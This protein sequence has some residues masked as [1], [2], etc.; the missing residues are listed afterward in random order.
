MKEAFLSLLGVVVGFGLSVGWQFLEAWKL[1]RCLRRSLMAE[2]KS[3]RR[4]VPSNL[5]IISQAQ[6]KFSAGQLLPTKST[7]FPNQVYTEVIKI[8]SDILSQ[9]ERDC[10]H[11]TYETLRVV[12]E[13]MDAMEERF[14]AITSTHSSV[15]ASTATAAM[16]GDLSV[17]LSTANSLVKSVEDG[18]PIN[19]YQIESVT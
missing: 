16:L 19:V 8:A 13:S 9:Q 2:L 18:K 1:R 14:N 17:A 6:E 5:D 4:M 11:I 3:I 10:L 12:D 7:H 15:H